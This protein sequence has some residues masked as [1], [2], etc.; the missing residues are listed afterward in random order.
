M[1][2]KK[3]GVS[4]ENP[5]PNPHP[6]WLAEKSWS[7]VVKFTNLTALPLREHVKNNVKY[8]FK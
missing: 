2:V 8:D 5:Y 6:E 7:E 4:L 1:L 3:G